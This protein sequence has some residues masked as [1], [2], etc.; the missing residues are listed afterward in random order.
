MAKLDQTCGQMAELE[1]SCYSR[2]VRKAPLPR[3]YQTRSCFVSIRDNLGPLGNLGFLS[4]LIRRK[5]TVQISVPTA[6]AEN[7]RPQGKLWFPDFPPI[8]E[9]D[10]VNFGSHSLA[11]EGGRGGGITLIHAWEYERETRSS[12]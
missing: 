8:T 2:P 4:F 12:R 10:G 7:P 1:R 5:S 11:L 9:I 6:L 3:L